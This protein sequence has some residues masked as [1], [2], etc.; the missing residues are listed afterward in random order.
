MNFY[1]QD[2]AK[3][4]RRIKKIRENPDPTMAKSNLLLYE[5]WLE[6]SERELKAWQEG[7]PFAYFESNIWRLLWAMG[8]HTVFLETFADRLK[9]PETERYFDLVRRKGYPADACDRTQLG[10]AL[11]ISGDLPRPSLVATHQN[12][13]DSIFQEAL[14]AGRFYKVPTFAMDIPLDDSWEAV[15]YV[16]EQIK[17]MISFAEKEVPGI[18]YDEQ[19]L[20]DQQQKEEICSGIMVEIRDLARVS[21]CPVSGRDA[22]RMP[23]V[24]L[25]QEPKLVDYLEALRDEL[26]DRVEQKKG[27]VE[28]ERMRVYWLTSAPF[29]YDAFGFLASRGASVPLYEEGP[30]VGR[31]YQVGDEVKYGRKLTPLEE[32]AAFLCYFHW[33]GPAETRRMEEILLRAREFNIDALV[34]F[35]QIGCATCN[36]CARIIAEKAEKEMGVTSLIIDGWCQDRDKFDQSAF[37]ASLEDLVSMTLAREKAT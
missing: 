24:D 3:Y 1:E 26:R 17:E 32:E 36:G 10:A 9:S 7:E 34:H 29:Y 30:G 27:A 37:E 22:L 15:Q 6:W 28:E 16:T 21:P 2:I 14:W 18:K 20:I 23:S 33:A 12:E 5:L 19:K 35:Q 13:C 25:F 4:Q 31:H 11:A 8:F